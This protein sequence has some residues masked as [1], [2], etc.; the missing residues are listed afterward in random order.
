MVPTPFDYRQ[1]TVNSQTGAL[2]AEVPLYSVSYS[3][4]NQGEIVAIGSVDYFMGVGG[5]VNTWLNVFPNAPNPAPNPT[6]LINCTSMMFGPC[7]TASDVQLDHSGKYLFFNDPVSQQIRVARIDLSASQIVDAGSS[8]PN[9]QAISGVVFSSDGTL[10]Y[11]VPSDNSVPLQIYSFDAGSGQL[12]PGGSHAV[13]A[14][15][16]GVYSVEAH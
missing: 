16:N 7:S 12:R 2:G 11:S 4:A 10:V 6:P 3:W 15:Y 14:V 8:I 13:P 1:R 9:G 5:P